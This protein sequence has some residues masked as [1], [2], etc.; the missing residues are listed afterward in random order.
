MKILKR[1]TAAV[2]AIALLSSCSILKSITTSA[3][4]L[5]RDTGSAIT[6]LYK[7]LGAAGAIDLSSVMNILNLGQILTGAHALTDATPSFLNQFSSGLIS[8]SDTLIN[9]DNVAGVIDA[10]KAL[11][12]VDSSAIDKA[13]T[14]ANSGTTPQLAS[15][16]IGV[17]QTLACLDDIFALLK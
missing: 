16:A 8:G 6:A 17:P 7:V 14:A 3:S 10:L 13:V 4:S 1:L 11:S 9:S 12:G 5:G 2:A 15:S